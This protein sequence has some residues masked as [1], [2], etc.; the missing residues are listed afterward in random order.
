M[1]TNQGCAKKK[2]ALPKPDGWYAATRKVL[3][4]GTADAKELQVTTS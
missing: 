4:N 3:S 2:P 1:Q